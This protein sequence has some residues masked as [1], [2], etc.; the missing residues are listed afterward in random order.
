MIAT[1]IFSETKHVVIIFGLSISHKFGIA[2]RVGWRLCI[3][4]GLKRIM[5]SYQ[6]DLFI[7]YTGNIIYIVLNIAIKKVHICHTILFL[8]IEPSVY[9][10]IYKL[11]Y[12]AV[13]MMNGLLLIFHCSM[14]VFV[15]RK[16]P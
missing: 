12:H 7:C 5:V 3:L 4:C 6:K 16:V 15:M 8:I 14:K 11:S 2:F 13:S 10:I 1:V 9:R